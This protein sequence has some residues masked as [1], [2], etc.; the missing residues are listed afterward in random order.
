M[1]NPNPEVQ[2]KQERI[3]SPEIKEIHGAL[4]KLLQ[5][6][7]IPIRN[8]D[9]QYI[10]SDDLSGRIPAEII[11]RGA[12]LFYTQTGKPSIPIL[13]IR[14]G[15]SFHEAIEL[16]RDKLQHATQAEVD[17]ATLKLKINPPTNPNKALLITEYIETGRTMKNLILQLTKIGLKID[18]ASM[19]I[20]LN[21]DSYQTTG[22]IPSGSSLFYGDKFEQKPSI[23]N[24]PELLGYNRNRQIASGVLN[25]Q[26]ENDINYLAN[27]FK[28][29][30]TV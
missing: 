12:N 27:E 24:K 26:I 19:G 25:P 9:F 6:L 10:I 1:N 18:V 7:V 16:R 8:Q 5:K 29:M 21:P 30:L 13:G 2:P 3:D 14:G 4:L 17:I 15:W 22:I 28:Q 11:Q 20:K 23:W